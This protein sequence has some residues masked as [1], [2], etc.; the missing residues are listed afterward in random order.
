MLPL[1]EGQ[2]TVQP[3]CVTMVIVHYQSK[4]VTHFIL[5]YSIKSRNSIEF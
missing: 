5:G 3:A 1:I 4:R 2:C